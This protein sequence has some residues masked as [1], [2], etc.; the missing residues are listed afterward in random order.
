MSSLPHALVP[1]K[2][3]VLLALAVTLLGAGLRFYRLDQQSLWTDE[4]YSIQVARAP[5]GEICQQS[6]RL[7][8]SLP[9]YFLLLRPVVGSQ[10]SD[11]DARARW[12]S[13]LAGALTVPVFIGVVLLWRKDEK[14]ALLAGL[15]LAIN[16]LHLW[17][18]QEARAY[19]LMLLFGS[20]VWLCFDLALP[21]RKAVWGWLY[22]LSAVAAVALHKTGLFFPAACGLWHGWQVARGQAS[23]RSLLLQAPIAALVIG[24]LA[25]PSHPPTEGYGRSASILEIGYTFLTFVG[26]YSFG[27]SLTEI[28]SLGPWAAVM[29][30][31]LQVGLLLVT[32][33]LAGGVC[34][35]QCRGLRSGREALYRLG[36]SALS[37]FTR[38]FQGS[39]TTCA[40]RWR[41]CWR[42]SLWWRCQPGAPSRDALPGCHGAP[43]WWFRCGRMR[44]GS[45]SLPIGRA[46]PAVSPAG[47]SKT[48]LAPRAGWS[49][50][51]IWARTWTGTCKPLLKC[52]PV[53]CRQPGSEPLCSLRFPTP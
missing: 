1:R 19:A 33:A 3:F 16:P 31:P 46:T 24:T 32:L 45:R 50:L 28:Q 11:L 14:V 43:W 15:L 13:A 2:Q 5:L 52:V 40:T 20:L 12:L 7:N 51:V 21:V 26:G 8:N 9:A 47:W 30:H 34:V 37:G 10:G 35:S 39:R 23:R 41:G 17:Y 38:W 25:L 49:C 4:V 36:S 42:F 22:A 18:S 27:P 44:S 6:A 53:E 29:R 48:K